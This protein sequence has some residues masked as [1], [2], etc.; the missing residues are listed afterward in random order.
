MEEHERRMDEWRNGCMR[1]GLGG[2]VKKGLM[3]W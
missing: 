2:F 1:G 3:Y